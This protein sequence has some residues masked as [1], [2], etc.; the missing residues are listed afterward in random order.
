LAVFLFWLPKKTAKMRVLV[1]MGN[2]QRTVMFSGDTHALKEAARV[3][4]G[5]AIIEDLVLDGTNAIVNADHL[6]K[7]DCLAFVTTGLLQNFIRPNNK[8][9]GNTERHSENASVRISLLA[10]T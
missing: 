6:E 9:Y 5:K 4:F 8:E 2:V 1:R 10:W 3:E 7:D